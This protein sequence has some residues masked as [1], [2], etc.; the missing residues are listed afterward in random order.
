MR[1]RPLLGLFL[2]LA[3]APLPAA[4]GLRLVR[5]SAAD[6]GVIRFDDPNV[7]IAE[8]AA[9]RGAPLLVFLPGTDGRPQNVVPL[10]RVAAAQGYRVIGLSYDD[11]PAVEQRCPGDPDPG[12]AAR[13]RAARLFGAPG[14]PVANPPAEAIVP[15]LTALLR[16]LAA[17]RPDQGWQD[18][19]DPAGA[20][21]WPMI[22]LSGF[23]QGAGMAAFLAKRV[24]VRR[25]VLFS[26]PWDTTGPERRPAPWLATPSATPPDR[27]WAERHRRERTTTLLRAAYAT[28]GI[29]E[30]QI[31]LIDT[32]PRGP[33]RGPNPY[34]GSTVANPDNEDAWRILFGRASPS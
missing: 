11:V 18:Y 7:V 12:C 29:P 8:G 16:L 30:R 20:P 9:D 6:P 4:A 19:L 31:L 27:W 1:K 26:S 33:G 23:S 24:A 22:A 21:R 15:R 25:V 14:G 13:F 5:P 2:M 32:E 34:H 3:A 10:L 17:E 28:L